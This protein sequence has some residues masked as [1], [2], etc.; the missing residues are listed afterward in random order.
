MKKETLGYICPQTK[1]QCD[2]ECCV[3][4]EDCHIEA[5][6]GIVYD[7]EQPKQETLEEAKAKLFR[8]SEEEVTILLQNIIN[9]IEIRKQ[10]II[11]KSEKMSVH[12]LEGGCMAFESSQD[13]VKEQVEQFK[14]K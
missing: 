14:K 8:Y 2:D 1:K 10:N 12:L 5:S 3:S 11:S 6:F 13:V 7:C 4:A 9:E